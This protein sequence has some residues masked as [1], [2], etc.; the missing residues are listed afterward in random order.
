MYK[1][2]T[3][4]VALLLLCTTAWSQKSIQTTFSEVTPLKSNIVA[5]AV[6]VNT[7][8]DYVNTVYYKRY[9]DIIK[10][11]LAE[12]GVKHIRDHFGD[13][14]INNRYA[15]LA[16]LHNIRLLVIAKDNGEDLHHLKNE[17]KRLNRSQQVVEMI[18]AANERDNGWK[19]NWNR[20]CYY[21]KEFYAVFKGDGET[22]DIPLVGPS[23]ANT[24]DAAVELGKACNDAQ[25]NMDVG[26][27]HAY[28]GLFPESPIAGGWG[29]SLTQA[30][31]NYRTIAGNKP[32]IESECGY[33][34]S[35]GLDGHPAVSQ[36]TAAKYAPRLVLERMRHGINK[37]YFYQLINDVEDFGLLNNDGSPREQFVALKNLIHLTTDNNSNFTPNKVSYALTGDTA[38]IRQMVLQ[39]SDGKYLLMLWQGV[40]GSNK[41][42]H[43]NDQVDVAVADK[44]VTLQLKNKPAAVRVFRPSFSKMPDGNGIR[45]VAMYNGQSL[46]KLNVPDHIVIVE[47]TPATGKATSK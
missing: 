12:L 40:S 39:K 7:H 20:L 45:P 28:S 10:P 5:D 32:I 30:I 35:E 42:Y 26:N 23:F 16:R 22:K 41:G 43:H 19:Q 46:V 18:E 44:K 25:N 13:T 6:G 47:I 2:S 36:R 9:E 31:K 1:I 37:L 8:L 27:I 17:V 4:A 15:E 24:R 34:M 29:I 38:N 33:K 3:C 21:L 14:L 11:R